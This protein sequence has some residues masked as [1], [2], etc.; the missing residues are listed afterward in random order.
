[1]AARGAEGV[2]PMVMKSLGGVRSL[3]PWDIHTWNSS[4]REEKSVST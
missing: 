1:M 3:S 2:V 4:G